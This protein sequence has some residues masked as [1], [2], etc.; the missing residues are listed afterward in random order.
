MKTLAVLFAI[1]ILATTMPAEIIT[2]WNFNSNP[3]DGSTSIGTN[4]PAVG[5]GV[6][7]LTGGV[8]ATFSTGSTNDV[9]ADNSAWN[10]TSYPARTAADKTAGARFNVSTR[11]FSNIVVSFDERVSPGASKY[12]QLQYSINGADFVDAAL[13]SMPT[14]NQFISHSISLAGIPS[15]NNNSNFAFQIVTEFESSATGSGAAEYVTAGTA[16][17][18]AAGTIRFDLVTISG[19]PLNPENTPPTISDIADQITVENLA[20]LEVPFLVGDLETLPGD[21]IV[22]G[23]SSDTSL[24][25]NDHIV[26][27][28]GGSNRTVQITP[29]PNQFGAA[30][31]TITVTDGDGRST[32]DTFLLTVNP[33]NF[34]PTISSIPH[35]HTLLNTVT[36]AINFTISD[37]ETPAANLTL[38]ATS[39]NPG[40]LPGGNIVFGGSGNDRTATLTPAVD[41]AGTTALT[42]TVT[43]GGGRS[44]SSSFVLM[45]VP[46]TNV[47]LFES[48]GYPNGSL[49][50][51]SAFLWSNHSGTIG[52]LSL[53]S[54]Q[55]RI[56]S[57][58]S[59]DLHVPLIGAPYLPASG[60]TL[61]A[62]FRVN[63]SALPGSDG[64]YFAHYNASGF[65]CRVFA[66]TTNAA[67]GRFR[68]GIANNTGT[69]AQV[70]QDLETNSNYTIVT[71]YNVGTGASAI[72]VNPTS[73]S[74]PATLAADAASPVTVSSFSFRQNSGIG[75]MTVDNLKV[76]TS[77]DDAPAGP[78]LTIAAANN[79]VRISWPASAIGHVLQSKAALSDPDWVTYPDGPSTEG[80]ES[81]IKILN[82]TGARFFRLMKN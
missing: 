12:A 66:S 67:P 72:W 65:R 25:A 69:Q 74:D 77:F 17:Y 73:E 44:A 35:Q 59:E 52:Q 62:S 7:S 1:M 81:V 51:N 20:T 8:S 76:S 60:T 10:T 58:Q 79:A 80:D 36:P 40:L 82:V 6:A 15:V 63:F 27:G 11:N 45:V 49:I 24:V 19:D 30:I 41:Q 4:S 3:P 53:G 38:S 50:T 31:I 13:V 75:V 18:S 16:S 21:L 46:S 54:E 39:S 68:L 55:I 42:I 28:G 22:I 56:S 29:A 34:A 2:L 14:T 57:Q 23:N 78:R 37:T 48:F 47:V 71:R 70:P 64:E 43:D 26:F 32:N 61:Y 33:A 5:R 9:P